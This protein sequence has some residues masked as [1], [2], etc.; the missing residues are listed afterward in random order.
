METLAK[1]EITN[2]P[3]TR[4]VFAY[5]DERV[6]QLV[7]NIKY[8]KSQKATDIAAFGLFQT[9]KNHYR[10]GSI[11]IPMP[12]TERR[13]KERGFNQT[14]LLVDAIKNLDKENLFEIDKDLL[15]RVHHTSRQTLKNR[16]ERIASAKGLFAINKNV[17]LATKNK[18]L[19][20]IDD[21]ITTG[22]TIKEAM[23]TLQKAGFSR[24][25]GLSVAH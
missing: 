16:E 5:K 21:V 19:I 1:A 2:V 11:L 13:L 20:V 9:L 14:H 15:I 22:S 23:E 12:I 25:E 17:D 24:I 8:K 10:A 18:N 6:S 3:N 4:S 7:W